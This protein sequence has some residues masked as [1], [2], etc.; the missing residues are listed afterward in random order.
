MAEF[1]FTGT[2]HL[3]GKEG[4]KRYFI[5]FF[6]SK[7][8]TK[9]RPGAMQPEEVKKIINEIGKGKRINIRRIE[10]DGTPEEAPVYLRILDIREDHFSGKIVNVE[11]SIKQELDDKLVYVKGGGGNID[12]YFEDGD[13]M[14]VEEDSDEIIFDERNPDELLE[15]LDA[16]DLNEAVLLSYYDKKKSGVING[17]G[18]LTEKD[19][20]LK[21]FT[22][23]M[24]QV[25]DIELDNPKVIKLDLNKDK[26]LD[27]EVML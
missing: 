6:K 11:R 4:R 9:V 22:V 17:I 7:K 12:F 23:E 18:R 8:K 1:M 14:S 20:D 27:L 15:I 21:T 16:L 19:L 26:V 2:H 24:K 13:I 10:Y 5:N 25:N 3:F